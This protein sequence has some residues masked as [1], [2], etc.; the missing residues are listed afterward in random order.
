MTFSN[1]ALFVVNASPINPW[2]ILCALWR[3]N[4]VK[5]ATM[6]LV[7][8]KWWNVGASWISVITADFLEATPKPWQ[9]FIPLEVGRSTYS[10]ASAREASDNH[11]RL[12]KRSWR[13]R[14]WFWPQPPLWRLELPLPFELAEWRSIPLN[15]SPPPIL[16]VIFG[17]TGL[18]RLSWGRN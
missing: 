16:F 14:K 4:V 8:P 17:N 15:L 13:I 1:Y 7:N 18:T 6:L 12:Q 2:Q 5:N 11:R 10:L 9:H 3:K